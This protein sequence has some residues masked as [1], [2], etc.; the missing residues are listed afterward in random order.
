M[1]VTVPLTTFWRVGRRA[2]PLYVL[3][4]YQGDGRFDDPQHLVGVL[5]CASTVETCLLELLRQWPEAPDAAAILGKIPPPELPEDVDDAKADRQ[6]AEASKHRIIPSFIFDKD[7]VQARSVNGDL[8]LL[9]LR[10]VSTMRR[11][12]TDPD[13]AREMACYSYRQFDRG[14]LLAPV[15][16]RR[17]TQSVSNAVLRGVFLDERFDGLQVDGRHGGDVYVVFIGAGY[18]PALKALSRMQLTPHNVDLQKVATTL[19]LQMP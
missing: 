13:V 1:S 12:E 11:L 10:H 2:D 3:P 4:K 16:H 8:T 17:L 5:Y 9:D 7:V 14:T 6:L 18:E 15:E 19:G